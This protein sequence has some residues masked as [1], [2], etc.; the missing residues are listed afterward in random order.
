L[1]LPGAGTNLK[2]HSGINMVFR[3]DTELERELDRRDA[4]GG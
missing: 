1:D 3:A 2:D 4:G